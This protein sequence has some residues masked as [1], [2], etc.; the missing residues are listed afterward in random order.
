VRL[1]AGLNKL[2]VPARLPEAAEAV[3]RG[4]SF[5]RAAGRNPP[6]RLFTSLADA[7]REGP[8]RT[9]VAALLAERLEAVA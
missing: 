3:P 6:E 9:E 5:H 7:P 8:I 4:R 1:G 2:P